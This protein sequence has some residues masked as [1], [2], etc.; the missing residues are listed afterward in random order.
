[1]FF[2]VSAEMGS[3]FQAL[4]NFMQGTTENYETANL[5]ELVSACGK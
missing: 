4:L 1:M 2:L 5:F 3:Y